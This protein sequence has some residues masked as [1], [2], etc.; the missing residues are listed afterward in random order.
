MT[1]L[2]RSYLFPYQGLWLGLL[3]IL[4]LVTPWLIK[5]KRIGM[6]LPIS[7]TL[8]VVVLSFAL[9]PSVLEVCG[10]ADFGK[11]LWTEAEIH[12]SHANRW[13]LPALAVK[14]LCEPYLAPWGVHAI[15]IVALLTFPP[16]LG[17]S[18]LHVVRTFRK[19]DRS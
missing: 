16:I 6:W 9:Y 5:T 3:L 17:F 19:K 12:R 4:A 1:D 11:G 7:S 10:V 14:R 18:F 2:V 13:L 15:V 8:M